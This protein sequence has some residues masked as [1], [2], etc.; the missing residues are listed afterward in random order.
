VIDADY[1]E[2]GARSITEADLDTVVQ[3]ADA[4]EQRFRGDGPLGR[5]I[6]DGRLL[7]A[8]VQGARQGRYRAVPVWTLSAATFALLYVLNPL[9]LVPDALPV[10]GL[11]DDAAVVSG[12]LA[13]VEQD[14]Y[15]YRRWRQ[16]EA[17]VGPAPEAD[18]EKAPSE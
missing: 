18:A 5:L 14:L 8:L 7:L 3:R 11:L 6:E 15:A 16:T 17:E 13:L 4:I 10:L 1:V 12:C 2:E 9:D